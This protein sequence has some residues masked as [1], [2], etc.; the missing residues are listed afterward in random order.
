M[1]EEN[2]VEAVTAVEPKITKMSLAKEIFQT[3]KGTETQRASFIAQAQLP[4]TEGGAD[5][6]K[7]GAGTYYQMLKTKDEGGDM[8]SHHKTRKAEADAKVEP[9]AK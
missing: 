2:A 3:V 6:T 9:I 4:S 1:S 7:A 5:L 8:Y